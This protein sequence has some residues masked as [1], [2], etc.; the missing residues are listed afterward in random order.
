[1]I[2]T[3]HDSS[4]TRTSGAWPTWIALAGLWFL[5]FADQYWVY[6][7][8]FLAWAGYDLAT[9]ESHFIQRITRRDQPVTYWLVVLTWVLLSALWLA[10][11]G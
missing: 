6:A 3:W 5:T 11:P 8:L 10:Y 2:P 9:G 4:Q 7:L 1:M